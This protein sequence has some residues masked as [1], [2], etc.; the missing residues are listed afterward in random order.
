MQNLVLSIPHYT[1]NEATEH[2]NTQRQFHAET[3]K[4]LHCVIEVVMNAIA[5]VP[6]LQTTFDV[7]FT[8]STCRKMFM[9]NSRHLVCISRP[10][11]LCRTQNNTEYTLTDDKIKS[12]TLHHIAHILVPPYHY[13]I[14]SGEWTLKAISIGCKDITSCK[15]IWQK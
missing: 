1:L 10:W 4:R 15:Y 8:D 14:H 2:C 12:M 6:E 11:V 9:I 3:L 5:S 7:Q 13:S